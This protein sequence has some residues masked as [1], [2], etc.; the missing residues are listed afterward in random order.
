M[1][2]QCDVNGLKM[3]LGDKLKVSRF[4]LLQEADGVSTNFLVLRGVGD[5]MC[6]K[7]VLCPS[8]NYKPLS[9]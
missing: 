8:R 9:G 7:G 1:T 2:I 5:A 6:L 4:I 3:C